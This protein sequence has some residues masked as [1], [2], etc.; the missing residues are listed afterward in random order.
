MNMHETRSQI[1]IKNSL[2]ELSTCKEI[3]ERTKKARVGK[4]RRIQEER[5]KETLKHE[6]IMSFM[7]KEKVENG[8]ETL[9]M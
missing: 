1:Y 4:K 6:Q 9:I 7:A 8:T 5:K 2:E 3:R